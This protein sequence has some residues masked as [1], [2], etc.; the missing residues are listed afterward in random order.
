MKRMNS[1]KMYTVY[2]KGKV[3]HKQSK[4]MIGRIEIK[5]RNYEN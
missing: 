1:I 2:I 5:E 3:E 4:G